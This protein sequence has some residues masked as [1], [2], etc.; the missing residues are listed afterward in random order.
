[1]QRRCPPALAEWWHDV[2]GY[3]LLAGPGLHPQ[4]EPADSVTRNRR[5]SPG[6]PPGQVR[7]SE[8]VGWSASAGSPA[9]LSAPQTAW[10]LTRRPGS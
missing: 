7:R 8:Q 3:D 6:T 1:M 10:I 9:C 5:G 4:H 2:C